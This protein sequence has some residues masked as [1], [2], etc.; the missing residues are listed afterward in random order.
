VTDEAMPA[1]T[2]FDL[3]V[4]HVL[5][6]ATL[7]RLRELYPAGRF[8]VR[9]FRPNIVIAPADSARR[10]IETTWVGRTLLV[11]DAI[12]LA[13]TRPCGRCV[14]TTLAQADLP[15]DPGILRTAVQHNQGHVGVYAQVAHGGLVRRGDAVRLE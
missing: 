5:T 3:G 9:R 4:V 2:F 12:R 1:N 15:K 10:F 14:M 6:T 7:N 8:E 11:G 13:I